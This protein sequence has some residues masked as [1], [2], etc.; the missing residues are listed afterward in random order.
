MVRDPRCRLTPRTHDCPLLLA[1][2]P[3]TTI[4]SVPD[5]ALERVFGMV[6][7]HQ[8]ELLSL[9]CTRWRKVLSKPSCAWRDFALV[10][11]YMFDRTAR[12]GVDTE[13][14]ELWL[15]ARV[16]PKTEEVR[17]QHRCASAIEVALS[18][19][20]AAGCLRRVVIDTTA[21]LRAEQVVPALS[22]CSATLTCL[23]FHHGSFLLDA[24]QGLPVMPALCELNFD[25]LR[26]ERWMP[27][28][29][30]FGHVTRFRALSKRPF[31][32]RTEWLGGLTSVRRMTLSCNMQPSF[33]C[34]ALTQLTC[35]KWAPRSPRGTLVVPSH[36]PLSLRVLHVP[37]HV[38]FGPG[39]IS[40]LRSLYVYY[41]PTLSLSGGNQTTEW[42]EEQLTGNRELVI[43]A[44]D[45]VT[46]SDAER[47]MYKLSIHSDYEPPLLVKAHVSFYL[48]TAASSERR[49]FDRLLRMCCDRVK[50]HR[51]LSL[52]DD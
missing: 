27:P 26:D 4:C 33:C 11:A 19:A 30:N 31:K 50:L 15:S 40:Q 23:W 21:T 1:A 36:L 2:S 34:S 8:R 3:P 9:V 16:G 45:G 51:G 38:Y 24:L 6:P 48:R 7:A 43:F 22:A 44:N 10:D 42:L 49:R 14:L 39:V 37:A 17:L 28:A 5:D 25:E 13:K 47:C 18:C 20:S 35:L 32:L 29:S 52:F 41:S 46:F 12:V